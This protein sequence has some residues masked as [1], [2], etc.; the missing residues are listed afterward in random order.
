MGARFSYAGI[1]SRETPND[2]LALMEGIAIKA[3]KLGWQLRSGGARGA[4]TAFARSVSYKRVYLE[5]DHTDAAMILAE[6]YHPAWSK[7]SPI[8]K[9]LHARNGLILLGDNLDDPVQWVCCWTVGGAVTGGTGQALRIAMDVKFN[10]PIY[11]L[12]FEPVRE[13]MRNWC[14]DHQ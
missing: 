13:M 1:G 14:N 9:R 7:C 11:N 4:D 8:A 6:Q 12:A 3:E 5:S 2:I 10:I